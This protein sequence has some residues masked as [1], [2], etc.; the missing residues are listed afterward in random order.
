[1][2]LFILADTLVAA[3]VVLEGNSE[4]VVDGLVVLVAAVV[5]VVDVI[6]VVVEEVAEGITSRPS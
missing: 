4:D 6:E 5:V 2:T 1:M 3:A